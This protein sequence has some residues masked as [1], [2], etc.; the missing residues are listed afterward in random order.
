MKI[1]KDERRRRKSTYQYRIRCEQ[2]KSSR[3]QRVC[4]GCNRLKP[5]PFQKRYGGYW[6]DDCRR[7]AFQQWE[8]SRTKC[9][10]TKIVLTD[11]CLYCG[12]LVR[13]Y[14][15]HISS[16]RLCKDCRQKVRQHV[17]NKLS[18]ERDFYMRYLVLG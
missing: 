8:E 16:K 5:T 7:D 10:N 18:S 2:D 9:V 3:V 4:T 14:K 1:G 12:C 15:L 17:A 6:C 13:I 11:T